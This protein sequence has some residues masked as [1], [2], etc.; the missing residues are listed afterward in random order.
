MQQHPALT[1]TGSI[2]ADLLLAL[3]SSREARAAVAVAQQR[4]THVPQ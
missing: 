3:I 1:R 4:A 2:R